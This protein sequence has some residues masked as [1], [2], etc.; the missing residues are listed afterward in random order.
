MKEDCKNCEEQLDTLEWAKN[1]LNS[2][3]KKLKQ[4]AIRIAKINRKDLQRWLKET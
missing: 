3:E 2:Y 1:F 4:K